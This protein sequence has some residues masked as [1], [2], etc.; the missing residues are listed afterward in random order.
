MAH[1]NMPGFF[2]A[3]N[4]SIQTPHVVHNILGAF[5]GFQTPEPHHLQLISLTSYTLY[6]QISTLHVAWSVKATWEKTLLDFVTPNP[7]KT[8]V[9]NRCQ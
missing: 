8:S 1:R 5:E 3:V 7:K 6:L 9:G 2:E 4:E